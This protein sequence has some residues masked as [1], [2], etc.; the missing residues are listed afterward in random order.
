MSYTT[1]WTCTG[2]SRNPSGHGTNYILIPMMLLFLGNRNKLRLRDRLCSMTD[3]GMRSQEVHQ[4]LTRVGHL[5]AKA[6]EVLH[7]K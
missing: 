5:I 7:Q 4:L 1:S 6:N 2:E 3:S